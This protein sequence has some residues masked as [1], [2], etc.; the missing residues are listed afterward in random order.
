MWFYIFLI[1]NNMNLVI[2]ESLSLN[3]YFNQLN[4]LS[5]FKNIN[6]SNIFN[7]I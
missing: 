3:Q 4:N 2:V 5:T 7:Y 6:T 1:V